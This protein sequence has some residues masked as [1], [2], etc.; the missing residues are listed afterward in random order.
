MRKLIY[1]LIQRTLGEVG[2]EIR[3]VEKTTDRR[4]SNMKY[5]GWKER[6]Q[7][8]KQLGFSP[9][10]IL[11][12]GAFKAM[13]TCQVSGMFPGAKFI[14]IEPNPKLKNHIE[15]KIVD[16]QPLPIYEQV[17]LGSK[18]GTASLHFWQAQDA[19]QG[20]SLLE[21]VSGPAI[22]TVTVNVETIDSL[23]EKYAL[24]PDLIKLDLQG[25]EVPALQ[26]AQKVLGHAEF[27]MIEF[28]CLDAYIHRSNPRQILDI[29][30]DFDYCLYDIVSMSD[31]P[32]DGALTGGDF[33]FVKN[34]S[35]LRKYKGWQ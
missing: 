24:V 28:G 7:Q 12:G 26:G 17:A 21:H 1:K 30:Y 27:A 20:A 19:D 14:V 13:W 4:A 2:F 22:N 8:A 35:I 23:S 34:T 25:G 33:F 31:R 11:D 29:M 32:Y 10:V 6:L 5:R 9:Q 18:K 16:I 3:R 15:K